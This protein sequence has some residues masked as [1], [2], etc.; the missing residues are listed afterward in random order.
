MSVNIKIQKIKKRRISE[1]DFEN[2]QLVSQFSDHMFAMEY[3]DGQWQNHRIVPFGRIEVH[4]V[5]CA[6]H[7][8]QT[9]FEGLKA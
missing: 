3:T 1:I 7:Y 9:I 6:L 8:G 2:L 4:P 5:Y